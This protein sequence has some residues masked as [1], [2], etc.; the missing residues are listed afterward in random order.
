[1]ARPGGALRVPDVLDERSANG[2]CSGAG[3]ERLA[4]VFPRFFQSCLERMDSLQNS[5]V[6]EPT[7]K[8][9]GCRRQRS[10]DLKYNSKSQMRRRTHTN[11]Y[12]KSMSKPLAYSHCVKLI[13]HCSCYFIYVCIYIF[14]TLKNREIIEQRNFLSLDR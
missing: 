4:P 13:E 5:R 11:N 6:G 3:G 7:Q 12:P 1:M 9:T 14:S 8:S 2:H 10:T